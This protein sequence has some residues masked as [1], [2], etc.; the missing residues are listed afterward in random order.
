VVVRVLPKDMARVRASYLAFTHMND[1]DDNKITACGVLLISSDNKVLAFARKGNASRLGIP[2]GKRE[3]GESLKD[4]A[5]RELYEE[6]GI[7]LDLSDISESFCYIPDDKPKEQQTNYCVTF[8]V[9]SSLPSE[10]FEI[11]EANT[12]HEGNIEG[13]GVWV[14][15]DEFI[16]STKSAYIEYNTHLLK[17]A[18]LI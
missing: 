1:V 18:N 10:V 2:A 5:A 15:P 16:L 12:D 8:I 9:R 11:L 6:T 17:F 7:Q 14:E 3:S 4:C 13:Q